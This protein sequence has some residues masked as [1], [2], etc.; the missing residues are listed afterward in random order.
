[1]ITNKIELIEEKI[2]RLADEYEHAPL[3]DFDRYEYTIEK[4]L[5]ERRDEYLNIHKMDGKGVQMVCEFNECLRNALTELYNETQNAWRKIKDDFPNR[6][7]WIE[8]KLWIADEYPTTRKDQSD[9]A[10]RIWEILLNPDLNKM[11]NSGCDNGYMDPQDSLNHFLYLSDEPDDWSDDIV[12]L[13]NVN[14]PKGTKLVYATHN[15]G[16][17]T[18]FT[19]FELMHVRK[20]RKEIIFN[21]SEKRE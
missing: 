8:P 2:I 4:L 17:H 19:I 1:M 3:E 16:A 20:F 18:L 21:I 12:G 13:F 7:I 9:R 6:N 5:E 15:L 14:L 11:Y 10:K